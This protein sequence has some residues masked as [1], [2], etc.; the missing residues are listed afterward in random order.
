MDYVYDIYRVHG[1]LQAVLRR[2]S[3]IRHVIRL[4]I[5]RSV[6]MIIMH[7]NRSVMIGCLKMGYVRDNATL[8]IETMI[9]GTAHAPKAARQ[10][11]SLMIYVRKTAS[12]LNVVRK[13]N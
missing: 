8:Q 11:Y 3:K 1:A 6:A 7:A 4:A 2:C 9:C 10:I 13:I 12:S 5:I